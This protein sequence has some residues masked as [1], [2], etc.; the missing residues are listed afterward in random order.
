MMGIDTGFSGHTSSRS[1]G[2]PWMRGHRPESQGE[3]G[4]VGASAG[5]AARAEVLGK[6]EHV[7][8][9]EAKMAVEG[10]AGQ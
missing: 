2:A 4:G 8:V 7:H 10:G 5:G 6:S 3:D 9:Q 1:L